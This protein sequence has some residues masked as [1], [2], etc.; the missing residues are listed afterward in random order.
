[1]V[2]ILMKNVFTIFI[3]VYMHTYANNSFCVAISNILSIFQI[4]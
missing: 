3:D 2:A 4:H 1:M